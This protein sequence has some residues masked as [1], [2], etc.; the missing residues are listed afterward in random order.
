[1]ARDFVIH[2][3]EEIIHYGVEYLRYIFAGV[4]ISMAYNLLACTLRSLGDGKT[5][6]HAMMV[7]SCVNVALDILFVLVFRWGIPGAAIATLIAQGCSVVFCLARVR[8][9]PMLK[10]QLRKKEKKNVKKE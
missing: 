4:P 9:L 5:P 10:L 6:L 8:R 7:A 3:P 1:M 2:T